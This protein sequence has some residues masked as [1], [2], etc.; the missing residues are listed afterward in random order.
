MTH[1]DEARLLA[2]DHETGI[3]ETM[4][5]GGLSHSLELDLNLN[6]AA[7]PT[8]NCH[9]QYLTSRAEQST[10]CWT[11]GLQRESQDAE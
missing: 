10:D 6:S 9:V 1:D 11:D 4:F 8:N 3:P 2:A 5:I 7:S